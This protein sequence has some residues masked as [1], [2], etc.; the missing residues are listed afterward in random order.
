MFVAFGGIAH[1]YSPKSIAWLAA[2]GAMVGAIAAP[3]LEPKVF[4]YPALWQVSFAV[5]GCVLA[6]AAWDAPV[7][8]YLL[9]V[10]G[11]AV[12]GYIAPVWIKRLQVP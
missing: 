10:V 5:V 8:G 4:R 7:E 2:S 9:A 1:G 11:G 6:A 3:E 12:L